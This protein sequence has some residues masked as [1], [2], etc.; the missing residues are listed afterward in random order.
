MSLIVGYANK[1]N[2]IIMSDGRAGKNG[3]LSEH[4]N[5]TLKIN[6]N[7]ILGFAGFA[8][9]VK[10]FTDHMINQIGDGVS[11]Y[12]IN[13]FWELIIFLSEDEETQEHLKSSFVIIGR[14]NQGQMYTSIIGKSTEYK[15]NYS[16]VESPR[17]VSIGGTIDAE[18]IKTIYGNN[19]MQY[20]LPVKT[21]MENTIKEVAAL[22][23]SVNTNFSVV[24]I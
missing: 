5:K 16:Y 9:T 14:N 18:T 8:E 13:D 2:A 7:I 10:T 20:D 3:C 23:N 17:I 19:I 21:R 11:S 24:S 4:Y 15:L 22:D 1:D 12:F 6:D